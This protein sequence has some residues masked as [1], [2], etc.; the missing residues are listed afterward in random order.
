MRRDIEDCLVTVRDWAGEKVRSGKEPPW[1]WYQYMKLVEA[2]DLIH[3]G[4]GRVRPVMESSLESVGSPTRSP[5]TPA[6]E[7]GSSSALGRD[8]KEGPLLPM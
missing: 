7:A 8:D 3:H 5:K 1:A 4:Q 2:V 6:P